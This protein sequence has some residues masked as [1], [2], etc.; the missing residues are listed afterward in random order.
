M[1]SVRLRTVADVPLGLLPFALQAI[2]V[3]VY[4]AGTNTGLVYNHFENTCLAGST[5]PKESK[6]FA[7][8]QKYTKIEINIQRVKIP[9]DM[10]VKKAY[11]FKLNDTN[12]TAFVQQ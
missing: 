11:S 3:D 2:A 5:G 12:F 6:A 8:V 7:A 10:R 9:E 1:E 4:I